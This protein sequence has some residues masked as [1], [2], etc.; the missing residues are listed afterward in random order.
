[1][2][3][4]SNTYI[5]IFSTV[6]VIIVATLLTFVAESLR[7]LQ[8]KNTEV[9][10]KLDILRSVGLAEDVDNVE[11]KSQYVER[12]YAENITRSIVINMEGELQEGVDAFT[13]NLKMELAKS[14]EERNLPVFIYTAPDG[15]EIKIVPLQ[16]K[17]LWGPVWGYISFQQDM[18]T[19]YGAIFAH[20]KETPGLGAE[21]AEDF[22]Q[23]QFPGK[24][25]F[26][27]AGQFT[28]VK[29]LKGGTSPDDP[30]AVD[31]ISGGTITSVALQ[32]M[33]EECLGNYVTYFKTKS[34][35]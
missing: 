10:K 23:D 28:S 22:F 14:P 35:E 31:A 32:D 29:V 26:D 8:E 27:Q 13:I 24:R 3:S 30:H 11:D 15:Q 6:M 18:S 33:L 7:P 16:G 21:I 25:I 34:N 9:E 19:I 2:K 1:M 17:G 20:A 4:Y 12:E 5:F